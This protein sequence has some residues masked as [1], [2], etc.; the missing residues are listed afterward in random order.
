MAATVGGQKHPREATV[1][2]T[3]NARGTHVYLDYLQNLPGKTV[4]AAYSVRANVR[5]GVFA[6]VSLAGVEP[7]NGPDEFTIGTMKARLA[8]SGNVWAAL[9]DS[10]PINLSKRQWRRLRFLVLVGKLNPIPVIPQRK[11]GS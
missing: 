10:V 5:A 7:R 4:A 8:K 9:R 2:R 6:P 3:V 11:S 1:E